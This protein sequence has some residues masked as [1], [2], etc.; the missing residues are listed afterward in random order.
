MVLGGT[1]RHQPSTYWSIVATLKYWRQLML[2]V[3]QLHLLPSHGNL[4]ALVAERGHCLSIL[5]ELGPCSD[6]EIM[7]FLEFLNPLKRVN[8]MESSVF[9]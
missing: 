2:V 9:A 5:W 8:S 7:S 1:C 4:R 6:L 3:E